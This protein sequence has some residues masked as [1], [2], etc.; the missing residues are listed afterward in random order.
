MCVCTLF[1]FAT[2][3]QDE[4]A[5][6][7]SH[8][9]CLESV[10]YASRPGLALKS[11]LL[12]LMPVSR[13]SRRGATQRPTVTDPEGLDPDRNSRWGY[14]ARSRT[15][16]A[17]RHRPPRVPEEHAPSA[18]PRSQGPGGGGGGS[19][20]QCSPPPPLPPLF[21]LFQLSHRRERGAHRSHTASSSS[22]SPRALGLRPRGQQS[23]RRRSTMAATPPDAAHKWPPPLAAPPF[24]LPR[25][26]ARS[27]PPASRETGGVAGEPGAAGGLDVPRRGVVL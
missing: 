16:A 17:P 10:I 6:Y 7:Y 20:R 11:H 9:A 22:S 21:T 4:G 19:A 15:P 3:F 1:V 8:L 26:L 13:N 2:Q 5:F 27:R 14:Q 18:L 25:P 24:L 23:S 12:L